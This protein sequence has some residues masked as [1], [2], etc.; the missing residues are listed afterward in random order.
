VL[1]IRLEVP[2]LPGTG[3]EHVPV[4]PRLVGPAVLEAARLVRTTARD[5]PLDAARVR[6]RTPA[7]CQRPPE[8]RRPHADVHE[9]LA[10]EGHEHRVVVRRELGGVDRPGRQPGRVE[11]EFG[12]QPAE[13]AVEFEAE[14]RPAR[15]RRSSR[16]GPEREVHALAVPVAER[17]A[18]D[19]QRLERDRGDVGG[20]EPFERRRVGLADLPRATPMR[21]R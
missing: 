4:G 15:A 16:R 7:E 14:P 13:Q 5:A 20:L 11:A 18:G 2:Q 9:V 12:E 3:V 21:E 19:R 6:G 1:A 17:V 8:H 10:V